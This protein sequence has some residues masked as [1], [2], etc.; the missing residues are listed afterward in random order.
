MKMSNDALFKV[1]RVTLRTLNK[2]FLISNLELA[3]LYERLNS[4]QERSKK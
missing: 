4:I 3:I 2:R 1:V